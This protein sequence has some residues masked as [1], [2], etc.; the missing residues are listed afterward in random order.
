MFLNGKKTNVQYVNSLDTHNLLPKTLMGPY[1]KCPWELFQFNCHWFWCTKKG[2][3]GLQL[4]I[5]YTLW[6]CQHMKWHQQEGRLQT[7]LIENEF[8]RQTVR[9]GLHFLKA[10]TLFHVSGKHGGSALFWSVCWRAGCDGQKAHW[11]VTV[12]LKSD[13]WGCFLRKKREKNCTVSKGGSAYFPLYMWKWKWDAQYC[14]GSGRLP[15]SA[16]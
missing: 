14:L 10:L 8:L 9:K 12:T 1:Q 4:S 6:C 16:H 2:F 5:L 13:D 7:Q 3:T 11:R 15:K